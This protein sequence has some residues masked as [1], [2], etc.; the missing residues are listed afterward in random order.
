[1]KEYSFIIMSI[2]PDDRDSE[3][4]HQKY[5]QSVEANSE[6]EGMEMVKQSFLEQGLPVYWIKSGW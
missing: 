1:M 2:D 6:E 4:P 3:D 5:Q